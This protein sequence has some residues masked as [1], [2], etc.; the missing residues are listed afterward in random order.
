MLY[1]F[2]VATTKPTVG[3][4]AV[5]FLGILLIS[6]FFMICWPLTALFDQK[7]SLKIRNC[8][9]FILKYP[10][11]TFGATLLT[12]A[13][14]LVLALFLPWS[15]ALLPLIGFW[16]IIFSSSFLLYPSL[17]EA[18]SIEASIEESF[19]DQVPYYETDEE[20]VKRKQQEN[21]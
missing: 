14:W 8:I 12:I 10:G 2:L 15:V 18:F 1:L 11:R 16:F 17:D 20:W 5:Y 9:L 6:L 4:L 13:Y 7:P 3:T 21:Q 19:P